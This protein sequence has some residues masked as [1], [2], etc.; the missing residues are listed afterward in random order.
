MTSS[1]PLLEERE[2]SQRTRQ[3]R[4][5][6]EVGAVCAKPIYFPLSAFSSAMGLRLSVEIT[7]EWWQRVTWSNGNSRLLSYHYST[8]S[9][10]MTCSWYMTLKILFILFYKFLLIVETITITTVIILIINVISGYQHDVDKRK[11]TTNIPQWT[12]LSS[13]LREALV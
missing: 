4:R 12:I 13:F 6:L 9:A 8:E 7:G 1:C 5:L 10:E 11:M 3:G 2:E